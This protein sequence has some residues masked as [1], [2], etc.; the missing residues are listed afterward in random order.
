MSYKAGSLELCQQRGKQSSWSSFRASD[1][2]AVRR[3][4]QCGAAHGCVELS[5]VRSGLKPASV[6]PLRA[7]YSTPWAS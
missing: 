1:S 2:T 4:A 3:L 5:C 7:V 6:L